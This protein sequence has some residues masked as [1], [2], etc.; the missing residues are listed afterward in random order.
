M[1]PSFKSHSI[2]N[3]SMV[4]LTRSVQSAPSFQTDWATSSPHRSNLSLKVKPEI[5]CPPFRP[6]AP[7]PILAESIKTTLY[8]FFARFSAVLTPVNP[9]P[10]IQT[11]E[12]ISSFSAGV[13]YGFIYSG[14]I[15]GR[16]VI[17][18]FIL[19]FFK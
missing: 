13:I 9:A 7:Q 3:S 10:T 8:P 18:F 5:N 15:I 12:E 4:C 2:P 11:S 1:N 17:Y 19:H 6:L 14:C 16:N